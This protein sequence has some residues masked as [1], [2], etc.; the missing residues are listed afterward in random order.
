MKHLSAAVLCLVL[1]TAS[2]DAQ[3]VKFG[4][5][6]KGGLAISAFQD[7]IQDFYGIGYAI[8]GHLDAD[9]SPAFSLRLGLDYYSFGADK[10]ELRSFIGN[11]EG[12]PPSAIDDL[13]GG[14][15]NIF[16]V[17]INGLGKLPT[18]SNIVP[19]G[20]FGVGIHSISLSDITG[21]AYGEEGTLTADD[22]GFKE[23]T[24]FGLNFGFGTEFH[25]K[26]MVL[27]VQAGYTLVFTEDETNGGIPIVVGVTFGL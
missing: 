18:N 12:I 17:T 2:A 11:S 20:L 21:N 15:V 7:L 5:G 25:M 8:G 3:E 10:D 9:I 23:G 24:K 16:A 1:V 6:V 26:S 27:F 13:S 19:Y 4:A 22:L 14:S